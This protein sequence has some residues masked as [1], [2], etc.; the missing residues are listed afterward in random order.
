MGAN[1]REAT[2][3]AGCGGAQ[4]GEDVRVHD[5]AISATPGRE[6]G[7]EGQD[8]VEATRTTTSQDYLSTRGDGR[9]TELVQ[10]DSQQGDKT[11]SQPNLDLTRDTEPETPRTMRTPHHLAADGEAATQQELGETRWAQDASDLGETEYIRRYY[12]DKLEL[13]RGLEMYMGMHE[14]QLVHASL[15][16]A[17]AMVQL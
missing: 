6:S 3:I 13:V 14:G 9:R 8:L 15:L 16:D 11:P 4:S 1:E 5:V 2:A 17:A 7:A 12:A 10:S